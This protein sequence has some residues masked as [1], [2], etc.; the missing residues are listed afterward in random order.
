MLT[1]FERASKKFELWLRDKNGYEACHVLQ[2]N[3]NPIQYF[4]SRHPILAH[5][6]SPQKETI[7]TTMQTPFLS[8]LYIITL[9]ITITTTNS[10]SIADESEYISSLSDL[11]KLKNRESVNRKPCDKWSEFQCISELH[12]I[13]CIPNEQRCD[14]LYHCHDQSDERHCKLNFLKG[15]FTAKCENSKG[16]FAPYAL[17]DIFDD[18]INAGEISIPPQDYLECN[19]QF[20]NITNVCTKHYIYNISYIAYTANHSA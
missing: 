7:S 12:G 9:I 3:V 4:Q 14:G 2:E 8:L 17:S 18:I 6:I 20:K 15:A 10:A 13:Q 5:Q 16:S 11:K 19:I 1:V